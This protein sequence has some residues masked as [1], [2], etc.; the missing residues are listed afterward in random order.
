MLLPDDRG[1]G[2]FHKQRG[3]QPTLTLIV[4]FSKRKNS[5]DLGIS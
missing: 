2:P 4:F 3:H 5:F 1:D